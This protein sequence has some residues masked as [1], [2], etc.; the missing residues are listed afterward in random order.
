[1]VAGK[2]KVFVFGAKKLS[3]QE[4]LGQKS[5]PYCL[6]ECGKD[7]KKTKVVSSN[8]NPDWNEEFVF[9]IAEDDQET[10][11]LSVWDKN[12]I[13]KDNFMGYSFASFADCLKDHE[14]EKVI[15]FHMFATT[16]TF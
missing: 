2:L 15:T 11:A 4:K 7:A 8:L 1:M 10:V 3:N 6:I 12:T 5:D 13:T 9:N 14:S 16:L